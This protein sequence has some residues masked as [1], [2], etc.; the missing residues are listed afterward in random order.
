MITRAYA[1]RQAL[2][3]ASMRLPTALLEFHG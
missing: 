3:E 2:Q 1:A